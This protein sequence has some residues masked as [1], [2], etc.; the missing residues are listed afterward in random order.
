M[1]ISGIAGKILTGTATEVTP[2]ICPIVKSFSGH[3]QKQIFEACEKGD[4]YTL[5]Q[6]INANKTLH[7]G[8]ETVVKMLTSNYAGSEGQ[9][10]INKANASTLGTIIMSMTGHNEK[11]LYTCI[12][13]LSNDAIKADSKKIS[14][15]QEALETIRQS[16]DISDANKIKILG[17]KSEFLTKN[18]QM[19]LY[20]MK[21]PYTGHI[22]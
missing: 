19:A 21:T 17:E 3:T 11:G 5:K 18:Q 9:I 13:T 1:A 22:G 4:L 16:A 14:M 2:K 20:Y 8:D 10:P 6:F 15:V 12:S 7:N